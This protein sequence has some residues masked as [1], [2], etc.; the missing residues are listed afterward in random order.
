MQVNLSDIF[1]RA[2][3]EIT[4]AIFKVVVD[5]MAPGG[6][7][8]FWTFLE[9]NKYPSP[10]TLSK[11]TYLRETSEE[12]YKQDRVMLYEGFHVYEIK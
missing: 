11:L 1:E 6:R 10:S 9:S 8:S 5:H 3:L 7:L 12:L 4:Q 2:D